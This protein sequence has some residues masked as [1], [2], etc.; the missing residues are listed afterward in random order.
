MQGQVRAGFSNLD[1][2]HLEMMDMLRDST[3]GRRW[4]SARLPKIWRPP[5]DV[6]ETADAVFVRVEIAGMHEQDFQVEL[7]GKRL[8]ISGVR[9]DAADKLGFQQMEIQYGPFETDVHLPGAVREDE[10]EATY[11][12]GFLVVYLPKATARRVP[13]TNA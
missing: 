1:R 12:G 4:V 6:Y 7:N 8:S 11:Q 13:V 3:Q 10:I 2:T 5:T 9:H